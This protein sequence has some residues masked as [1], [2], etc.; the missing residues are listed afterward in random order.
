MRPCNLTF[1]GLLATS[2]AGCSGANLKSASDYSA[3]AAPTVKHPYYNPY[4]P[5]GEANARW[6]PPVW[7]RDGTITRPADPGVDSGRPSYETAPW[8]TGASGG[9]IYAPPG[10][11]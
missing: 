1:I 4:S 10:T 5:Y 9:R 3:P 7:N 8:A 6:T 11:F 2:L